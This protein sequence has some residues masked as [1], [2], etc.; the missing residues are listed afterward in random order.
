MVKWHGGYAGKVLNVDLTQGRVEQEELGPEV[1]SYLG[2][3]GLNICRLFRLLDRDTDPLSPRNPLLFSAGPLAGTLFPGG[4][5]FNV[6]AKSPHTGILGDANAGGFFGPE[7]KFAGYDQLIISGRS[8][9]P[10]YLLITDG[11]VEIRPA[12]HLWG[13]DVWQTDKALREE[14]ADNRLQVAC[15][16]PAAERGVTFAGVFANLVRTAARTGMGTVMGAKNLKAVAVR[17]KG[18]INIHD[19]ERFQKL[20]AQIDAKIY[21]HDEYQARA[22][23]GT[24]KLINALNKFGCLATRHF[25]SGDFAG[26]DAV[27]GEQLAKTLKVKSKSC[28]ACT[29][30]CSRFFRIT[31]GPY[32]GLASE[33]P[34]FEGLAGFSSRVGCNDLAFA[35]QGV[36]DCNRLGM[37][38]I[39]ASECI[40][41]VMECF[42][43][44]LLSRDEVDGL[45]PRWG[46]QRAIRELLRKI[47]WREGIGDLLA[48]G[49]R[50]ASRTIGRGTEKLAMH[51]KGLEVFQADPRGLKGY[52]LGFALAS[53]GGDHL[54]SEPS[55]EFS[56]DPDE[57]IRRYG[58][59][60]AAFRLEY[61]G[62][63][64]LVKHYEEWSALSD[65]LSACKNTIVNME[66][67]DFGE[68][69]A[70]LAALTGGAFTGEGVQQAC[71]R[72]LN[73]ERAFI[74][75]QGIRRSDDTLPERFLKEPL[76]GEHPSK[77]SVVEL[78]AM[79]DEYYAARGWDPATG[80][81]TGK[82]LSRLGLA[83]VA[84]QL[85]AAGVPV[86]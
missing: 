69:A 53:R 16:G 12:E 13:R 80:I 59:R 18:C 83:D 36:D 66:I 8:E 15:I 84:R 52:A 75:R 63:G 4:A 34:E 58:A 27:S 1:E 56:N 71:E 29:I 28:F 49:V 2:G 10:V 47:A 51:I 39:T 54:R 65:C 85:L 42:E 77:G 20:L 82:T 5:R 6:S 68:A 25:L 24:T 48:R 55:F 14:L 35:L 3:R 62:K 50:H 21:K 70:L 86:I 73:L 41:F 43:K 46:D 11:R 45:E 31:S 33:G 67:I 74:V 57:G 81:P 38:V 17:G 26:A 22:M 30:P 72:V 61:R 32:A 44:G 60:E 78:E 7:L 19:R 37:D 40:S 76:P 79:L 64:R 9:K 23:M